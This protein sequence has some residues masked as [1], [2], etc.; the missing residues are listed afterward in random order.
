[1]WSACHCDA[2]PRSSFQREHF[3]HA[4]CW[5]YQDGVAAADGWHKPKST[6]EKHFDHRARIWSCRPSGRRREH[7]LD[8]FLF[9]FFSITVYHRRHNPKKMRG[10]GGG[11]GKKKKALETL[12]GS[13]LQE[14]YLHWA[15]HSG[16]SVDKY[17]HILIFQLAWLLFY[18]HMQTQR[19]VY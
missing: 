19:G 6:R 4:T 14:L 7:S 3:N 2:R 1:M 17:S 11:G 10:W 18:K 8:L 12:S 5:T 15:H 13:S 16:S 9:V